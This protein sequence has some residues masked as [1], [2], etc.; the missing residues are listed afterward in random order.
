MPPT[1]TLQENAFNHALAGALQQCNPLWAEGVIK[2]ERSG[3]GGKV[4]DIQID[5][6]GLPK[7]VLIETAYD[8][9]KHSDAIKR[10]GEEQFSDVDTVIA[11][12]I[13]RARFLKLQSIAAATQELLRG[14]EFQY[15]LVQRSGAS[16]FE[17]P[18]SGDIT[19]DVFD[20]AAFI[21]VSAASK[22]S[23][24]KVADKV[25]AKIV[26]AGGALKSKNGLTDESL[27]EIAELMGQND[28]FHT[29]ATTSILWLD[30]LLVHSQIYHAIAGDKNTTLKIS[31]PPAPDNFSLEE[32]CG[33]WNKI[34]KVNWNSIFAPAVEALKI[35]DRYQA[36]GGANQAMNNLIQAYKLLRDAQLGSRINVGAELF[37]KVSDD[38]KQAAAFYTLPATAELLAGLL[39]RKTDRDDWGDG[40]LFARMKVADFACGTGTLLRAAYHRIAHLHM[41]GDGTADT[42]RQLGIDALS[43]G[44]IGTDV[45]PIAAHLA[46]SSLVLEVGGYDYQHTQIGHVRVGFPKQH[47]GATNHNSNGNGNGNGNGGRAVKTGALEYLSHGR[48]V[49]DLVSGSGE[50]VLNGNG[51]SNGNGAS[52]EIAIKAADN[53]MDYV[54][55]NPPYTTPKG[56]N[57]AFVIA[58]ML[59]EETKACLDRWKKLTKQLPCDNN[60]GLAATFLVMAAQ[61]LK[62][63]GRL[64][65]VLPLTAASAEC[66]GITRQMFRQQFTDIVAIT[67]PYTGSSS[68]FSDETNMGEMLL[69]GTK[70]TAAD[71]KNLSAVQ[72]VTLTEM[73]NVVGKAG[74]FARAIAPTVNNKADVNYIYIGGDEVGGVMTYKHPDG[75]SAWSHLG[76]ENVALGTIAYDLAAGILND[77]NINPMAKISV[78]MKVIRDVFEIGPHEYFIG[79]FERTARL[80]RGACAFKLH[81]LT[82]TDMVAGMHRVLWATNSQAQKF[83]LAPPTHKGVLVNAKKFE[84]IKDGVGHLHYQ[85]GFG[86]AAGYGVA[87]TTKYK[88][89]GGAAFQTLLCDDELVWKSFA[90]YANSLFGMLIHW[91]V[92]Q[93]QQKGRAIVHKNFIAKIPCP[94][95]AKIPRARLK[96]VAAYYDANCTRELL[97]VVYLYKDQLRHE[98]DRVTAA[99]LGLATGDEVLQPI[100][101][102]FALEPSVNGGSPGVLRNFRAD[103]L[104]PAEK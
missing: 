88:I 55:M 86:Y 23:V 39:I 44:L 8:G 54:I 79:A 60:V 102:A 2:A 94:D 6:G 5:G 90:I 15:A 72:C 98:F 49:N 33:E 28:D 1:D 45:S 73:P 100:R 51:D 36:G 7:R 68:G 10:F 62:P 71:D 58:G 32:I 13:P 34:L 80:A 40:G 30:A 25:A 84:E 63:G 11:V 22:D 65:I 97:P 52:D 53:S 14:A 41:T 50:Y 74:E 57:G 104:L 103:G 78:E 83:L 4:A 89:F 99:M 75:T 77:I 3:G 12:G 93:R 17:F 61:K 92:A 56:K 67:A 101:E 18:A 20:L 91:L 26:G 19:G 69:L 87:L 29:T 31:A 81:E 9:D 82:D 46:V 27:N 16:Y 64:G 47:R 37:P 35:A 42:L 59:K 70:R 95:F 66:W 76:V 38:R 24:K 85:K 96:K 48:I 43:G 21:N